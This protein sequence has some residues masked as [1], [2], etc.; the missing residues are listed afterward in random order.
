MRVFVTGATGFIGTA[1]VRE[2]IG[3]GH[4]VLGLT[5]SDAGAAALQAAGAQAHF[6]SLEDLASLRQGAADSEGV[7]HLAFNHD[8]SKW[9]EHSE[10]DAG[11]IE[12]LGAALA[13]SGRPL[14]VT[15]GTAVAH[16]PGR[17]V[18]E[19]DPANSPVPRVA[20]EQAA[21][22]VL[23]KG[24]NVR[25]VRLPQVH[26]PLKQ[27]LITPL[28]AIA[29]EKGVSAYVGDGANRW[30]AAHISDVAL[31]YRLVL[32]KG[33]SGKRYNAVAE[34]GVAA[35]AIAEAVGKGL[36]IPVVSKTPEEA[37]AHFG[38]L[39]MLVGADIPASG[40]LTQH[41]LG[42]QPKGPSLLE[43]LAEGRFI[44]S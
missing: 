15:S 9:V 27:G 35:K 34:E 33:E 17:P 10:A 39:G 21:E 18:T 23:A 4:Q 37:Q 19:N 28:V 6:G 30:P 38:W 16:V 29:R 11:V 26:D 22:A 36:G 2:L 7:I 42:W 31:L 25:I 32:E 3:A 44:E 14:V 43:D 40:A 8:F 12:T 13:G 1:V 41:W 5:R 20:T 24:G